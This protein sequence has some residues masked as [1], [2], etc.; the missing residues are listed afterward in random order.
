MKHIAW[1]FSSFQW[2]VQVWDRDKAGRVRFGRACGAIAGREWARFLKFLRVR[3]EFK[4]CGCGAG[5]DEKLQPT[6]DSSSYAQ[7]TTKW[8]WSSVE[9]L[10]LLARCTGGNGVLFVSCSY[11]PWKAST[12]LVV[13]TGR[14][15]VA[16][17]VHVNRLGKAWSEAGGMCWCSASHA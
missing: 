9:S 12:K 6:Q 8:T 3:G 4:F 15:I 5:A 10:L 2:Q 14:L 17:V 11:L 1:Y 13:S 7:A 16:A